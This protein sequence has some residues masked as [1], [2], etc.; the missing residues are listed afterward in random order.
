MHAGPDVKDLRLPNGRSGQCT[1]ERAFEGRLGGELL[2]NRVAR[3]LG[4]V[5]RKHYGGKWRLCDTL[6]RNAL[7]G[8][9]KSRITV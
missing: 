9:T 7:F 3:Y 1:V 6:P 8:P 5:F 4:E 2:R